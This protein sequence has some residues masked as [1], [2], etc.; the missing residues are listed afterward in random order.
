MNIKVVIAIAGTLLVSAGTAHAEGGCPPGMIPYQGTN[1]QSC[2]PI[3]SSGGQVTP[4]GPKWASRWGAIAQDKNSGVL[5][6]VAN[7]E[8]KRTAQKDAVAEC[9]SRGGVNCK[10]DLAYTNQCVVTIQGSTAI[11]NARAPS[12]ERATQIGMEACEGR[13]DT[14]CHIYY[15]ACSLPV[16]VR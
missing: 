5:G 11:N 8:N 15:K 10:V 6:A 2:G 4:T 12:I 16:Q 7:R 14:D 13:G 1:T 3:P 9:A